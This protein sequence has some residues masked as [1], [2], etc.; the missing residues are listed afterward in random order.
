VLS[1]GLA[2]R[3][4]KQKEK[5]IEWPLVRDPKHKNKHGVTR[6][7]MNMFYSSSEPL[8]EIRPLDRLLAC[9]SLLL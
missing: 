7:V 6:Y 8:P 1:Q 4:S 5:E 3:A 2:I 9:W